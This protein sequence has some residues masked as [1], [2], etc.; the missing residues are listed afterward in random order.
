MEAK[1]R[2]PASCFVPVANTEPG[3]Q[4]VGPGSEIAAISLML[5]VEPVTHADILSTMSYQWL[6][7]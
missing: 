4:F 7:N 2:L 1:H 5:N 6:T 3:Q